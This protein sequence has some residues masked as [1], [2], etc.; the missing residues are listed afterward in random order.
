MLGLASDD[1]REAPGL[2]RMNTVVIPRARAVAF[3]LAWVMAVLH[4][5]LVFGRVDWSLFVP[6]GLFLATWAL[7]SWFALVR[8]FATTRIHLG[9]V[10]VW[11]EVPILATV[12]WATGG[13]ESLMWPIFF[14]RIADQMWISRERAFVATVAGMIALA[15]AF[16]GGALAGY[17]LDWGIE[18]FKIFAL[19]SL[20][21]VLAVVA[22]APWEV[23]ERTLRARDLI[24]E[25]EQR[26]ADLAEEER[27]AARANRAKSE[28][29][30]RVS[31]E[32]RGPMNT[33]VGLAN[34]LE[35]SGRIEGDD[36]KYLRR[37]RHNAL[38]L[39]ALLNDVID[40][41]RI[42]DGR[43]TVETEP[44]AVD[45]LV[46][47]TVEQLEPRVAGTP[48]QLQMV[49]PRG[50]R[51]I[52]ADEARLRQVL[53]HLVGNAIN[54]TAEGHIDV[55]M[56]ADSDGAPVAVHVRDT[57][58][59]IEQKV[60]DG[61]FDPFEHLGHHDVPAG[62]GF[63]IAVS[64]AL[65]KLMGFHLTVRSRPGVGSTFSVWFAQPPDDGRSVPVPAR[66]GLGSGS[67]EAQRSA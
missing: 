58:P 50:V 24:L 34:L 20:G 57:G 64:S 55:Q 8:W 25:L 5:E 38:H 15:A 23:R 1:L 44:V 17:E 35:R 19:G 53:I 6:W 14:L 37:L 39:L 29:L 67:G 65:C 16:Q 18:G 49:V 54:F 61:L 66:S 56:Q 52:P 47:E 11:V 27:I 13:G 28:F 9:D 59:G 10:F 42:E 60:L 2:V 63:G 41:S 36:A 21:A 32:L 22:G 62:T 43:L 45:E 7:G 3:A 4:N 12:V 26:A 30:R 51:P 46:R 31:G 48:I 40:L 33:V